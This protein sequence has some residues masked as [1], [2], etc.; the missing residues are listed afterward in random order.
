M[1]KLINYGIVWKEIQ[2]KQ[3]LGTVGDTSTF[4]K[5]E[6]GHIQRD[7]SNLISNVRGNGTFL[8]FDAQSEESANSIQAWC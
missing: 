4:L 6:L 8:G 3:L 5:V 1:V 7:Q 2:R